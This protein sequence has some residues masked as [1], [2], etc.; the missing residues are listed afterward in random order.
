MTLDEFTNNCIDKAKTGK[1]KGSATN[2]R[3]SFLPFLIPLIQTAIEFLMESL[4][5]CGRS[6]DEIV[7]DINRK[8]F[9]ARFMVNRAIAAAQLQTGIRKRGAATFA[10]NI[11]LEQA[12]ETKDEDLVTL[13]HEPDDY[14]F[15]ATDVWSV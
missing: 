11:I 1:V 5:N 4:G 13:L 9:S 7:G 6:D 8:S 2:V 14:V 3:F 15:D 10:K 12:R